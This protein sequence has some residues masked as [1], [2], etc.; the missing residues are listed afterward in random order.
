M[1][2]PG[3]R[4]PQSWSVASKTRLRRRIVPQVPLLLTWS[5]RELC[6]GC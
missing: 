1:L 4:A 6:C 2:N 3:D 5:Y